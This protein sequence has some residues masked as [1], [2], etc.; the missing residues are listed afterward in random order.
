VFFGLASVAGL[1]LFYALYFTKPDGGWV[2]GVQGRHLIPALLFIVV[3][4]AGFIGLTPPPVPPTWSRLL[5][6]LGAAVAAAVL[7]SAL[8]A[9]EARYYVKPDDVGPAM[10]ALLAAPA[11]P[12][13]RTKKAPTTPSPA[14]IMTP[15]TNSP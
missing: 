14:P 11:R 5:H 3:G 15:A 1:L 13:R 9:L 7:V 4:L 12:A 10:K 8:G 2:V 6:G